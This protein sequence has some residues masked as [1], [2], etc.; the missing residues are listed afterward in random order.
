MKTLLITIL[1]QHPGAL[2]L[3]VHSDDLPIDPLNSSR[4]NISLPL[5][6]N[7]SG[8]KK[9]D[10]KFNQM[11]AYLST[12]HEAIDVDQNNIPQFAKK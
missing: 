8:L 9:S 12:K 2:S 1:E 11:R 5:K 3:D 6:I 4:R 7:L 10:G